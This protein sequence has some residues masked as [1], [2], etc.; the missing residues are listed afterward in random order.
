MTFEHTALEDSRLS[1]AALS[2]ALA[3]LHRLPPATSDAGVVI[4]C[5]DGVAI[6]AAVAA[7]WLTQLK[8]LAPEEALRLVVSS[9]R[10]VDA[11]RAP[12]SGSLPDEEAFA[13]L[14]AEAESLLAERRAAA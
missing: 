11:R 9:G 8:K 3:K 2:D 5:L 12:I 1:P 13:R 7:A 14:L 6:G 10:D 4:V